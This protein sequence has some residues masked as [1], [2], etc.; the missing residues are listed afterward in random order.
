MRETGR[1]SGG[2][3]REQFLFHEIRIAARLRLGGKS[4]A[5]VVAAV[6]EDN[7]FQFPT[8]R[9]TVNLTRVCLKRLDALGAASLTAAL[10]GAPLEVAK[11]INLYAMMR[12]SLLVREFMVTVI[13]EK[14]RTQDFGFTKKDLYLFFAGLAQQDA[15]AASWSAQTVEKIKSVLSRSLIE[16][17]YIDSMRSGVLHPVFLYDELEQGIRENRDLSALPAFNR[18]L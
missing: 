13:G 9:M 2:L 3:T 18:F 1:Y 5:E 7:L 11:Q 16:T 4:D 14:Y 17:G 12:Y 10:A 15:A 8:E 6:R